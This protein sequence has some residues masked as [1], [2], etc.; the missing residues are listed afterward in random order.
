MSTRALVT[1][2]S[3][4]AAYLGA[5]IA[6]AFYLA[7]DVVDIH[8]ANFRRRAAGEALQLDVAVW[9][10]RRPVG[11]DERVTL[12]IDSGGYK[13]SLE[14]RELAPLD[15]SRRAD[16]SYAPVE[17]SYA[18]FRVRLDAEHARR[19]LDPYTETSVRLKWG[20]E[21]EVVVPA[22]R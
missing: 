8:S 22:R 9:F 1:A 14:W 16:G 13:R 21:P 4:L 18:V 15:I 3:A 6:L 5:G 11:D 20:S 12:D 2:L 7:A 10:V 19:A 17:G